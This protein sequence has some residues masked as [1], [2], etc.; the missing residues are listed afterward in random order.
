MHGIQNLPVQRR[1][2]ANTPQALTGSRRAYSIELKGPPSIPIGATMRPT[3]VSPVPS[4]RNLRRWSM[5]KVCGSATQ[6]PYRLTVLVLA[7]SVNRVP[8]ESIPVTSS[9]NAIDTRSLRRWRAVDGMG[10]LIMLV[11][12][13]DGAELHSEGEIRSIRVTD[14]FPS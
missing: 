10:V 3:A 12:R 4:R 9:P 11:C 5:A 14:A 8:E 1:G 7:D 2:E 6:Q 13:H